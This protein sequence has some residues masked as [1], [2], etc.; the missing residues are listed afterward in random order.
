MVDVYWDLSGSGRGTPDLKG[1]VRTVPAAV[2]FLLSLSR[3]AGGA[4]LVLVLVLEVAA[5]VLAAGALLSLTGMLAGLLALVRNDV[6]PTEAWPVVL[7]YL[8]LLAA[9]RA[10]QI[11]ADWFQAV[12]KPSVK[13]VAED[14]LYQV[15]VHTDLSAFDDPSFHDAMSR[16]RNHG[17]NHVGIALDRLLEILRAVLTLLAVAG[18]LSVLHPVL[19]P[20]LVLSALPTAWAT[21]RTGR[22]MHQSLNRFSALHRRMFSLARLL[23]DRDAAAEVRACTAHDLLLGERRRL[24]DLLRTEEVRVNRAEVRATALG[25]SL[26]AAAMGLSY[27]ALGVLFCTG[28]TPVAAAGGA[29][30]AIRNGQGAMGRIAQAAGRL[31]EQGLYVRDYADFIRD[32]VGRRRPEHVPQAPADFSTISLDG[33]TF[34]YPGQSVPAVSDVSLTIERGQVI[35]LVGENGSG[36]TTL[37]KLIAGLYLPQHGSVRWDGVDLSTLDELSIYRQVSFVMQTPTRW[38]FTAGENITIGRT[39]REDPS[40]AARNA[41][42]VRSAAAEVVSRLP[43]GYETLLSKEFRKGV[44]LSGGEWQR[45]SVARGFYR[46]APLLICDEPSAAMDA[47]AERH[48]FETL[49]G[50]TADRTTVLITH[51]L[52]GVRRADR[53]FLLHR[54]RVVEAGTHEELIAAGGRYHDLYELQATAFASGGPITETAEEHA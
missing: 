28:V 37:A 40:H 34:T 42:A 14:R 3:E 29:A 16:A 22:V 52:S 31:C 17:V 23:A 46:D 20:L 21:L 15:T 7:R 19:L 26:T 6:A 36:K 24:S 27:A 41:A 49:H 54:G 13:R 11:G 47:R 4:L 43:E 39:D 38:P 18:V 48:V 25:R 53:I 51:R 1:L 32:A 2:R 30:V 8:G 5:A 9:G 12:L 10:A 33:V 44:D 35:A 50:L 45:F